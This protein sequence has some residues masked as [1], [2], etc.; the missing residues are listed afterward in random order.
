MNQ[1]ETDIVRRFQSNQPGGFDDLYDQW[2]PR[3]FRFCRR[4]ASNEADAEDLTQE[5]FLAAYKSRGLFSWRSSITTWL[6]R[7]AV[8]QWNAARRRK[9]V[10]TVPMVERDE[11]V[12]DPSR[13]DF[14]RLA[15]SDALTQ[16]PDEQRTAF[17]LVRS[18]GLT[19]REAASVLG[20]PE[21]TLKF[22]VQRAASKLQALYL[23][24]PQTEV[25]SGKVQAK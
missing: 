21:P 5:V 3:V 2:G 13:D 7:I 15:F 19:C 20:I 24:L 16:L 11:L 1:L 6:L 8:F 17:I 18:E 12:V 22:R 23:E 4:L 25:R 9:R 14:A 10:G